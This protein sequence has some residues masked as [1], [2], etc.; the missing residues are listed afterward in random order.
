MARLADASPLLRAVRSLARATWAALARWL[1][2]AALLRLPPLQAGAA[3]TYLDLQGRPV[4]AA[5]LR[6]R[7][8]GVRQWPAQPVPEDHVLRRQWQ[9]PTMPA[10]AEQDAIALRTRLHS[11][12][13]ADDTLCL[14]HTEPAPGG[15][16]AVHAV[17]LSRQRLAGL[18]DPASVPP[19]LLVELPPGSQRWR[20]LPGPAQRA[21]QRWRRWRSA[22]A[23]GT[24]L[25]ALVTLA[26][27]A[28]TPSWQLRARVIDAD[29]QW[30]AL[31]AAAAPALDS[32]QRLTTAVELIDAFDRT[33]ADLRDPVAVLDWLTAQLP[34]D[35]YVSELEL[36]G[37]TLRI[38]GLTPNA[39]N[40]MR[41]LGEQPT[42]AS[43]TATRAATKVLGLGKESYAIEI[44]LHAGPNP[45]EAPSTPPAA[46]LSSTPAPSQ[47]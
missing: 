11:P 44:R 6:W 9:Q 40:L 34:D 5:R 21:L 14:W 33:T 23:A 42:V 19:L 3:P 20:L 30:A 25:L 45:A 32:R 16:V 39:A 10:Q 38:Q 36:D 8:W 1:Q 35:T 31:Q 26:A 22:A 13:P 47:P 7:R 46:P 17:W 24:W 4:P 18:S 2:P 41:R 27:A 15:Q 43:V 29:A 12:F 37:A 28:L